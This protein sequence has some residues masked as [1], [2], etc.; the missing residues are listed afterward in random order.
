MRVS[1]KG[2]NDLW[3][4]KSIPGVRQQVLAS[5]M[6]SG[7]NDLWIPKSIPGIEGQLK[8]DPA[9]LAATIFG[10]QRASQGPRAK[11]LLPGQF[12]RRPARG[13]L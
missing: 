9:R 2:R 3:I 8:Y 5:L 12:L 1:M 10:F 11:A 7:R 13:S 6:Y 4:P